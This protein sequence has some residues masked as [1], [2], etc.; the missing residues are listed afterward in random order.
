MRKTYEITTSQLSEVRLHSTG[1]TG[2]FV[3]VAFGQVPLG[4][5]LWS[6]LTMPLTG[7]SCRYLLDG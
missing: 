4:L 3:T 7:G 6:L 5:R 1:M 2:V